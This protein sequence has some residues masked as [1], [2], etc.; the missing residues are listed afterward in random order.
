MKTKFIIQFILIFS[1]AIGHAQTNQI[2]NSGLVGIGTTNPSSYLHIQRGAITQ[3]TPLL[4]V[5][6]QQ[7]NG[8]TQ[9]ALKGTGRQF[10]LGVGNSSESSFGIANKF[11]LWDQNAVLPRFVLDANGN[12]GIGTTNPGNRLSIYSA[13]ANTSGLQFSRLNN[14]ATAA[15]GNGKVLSLDANGNVILVVDGGTTGWGMT[16]N[17]NTN[18]LTNY[19]GTSDNQPIVFKTN[20]NESMRISASGSVSIGTDDAKGYTLAVNGDAVFTRIKV[21]LYGS[22][23]DYVF[24]S[25]YQLPTLPFLEKYVSE[26]KHLPGIAS[27]S[28]VEKGGVDLAETQIALLK[29]IEEL[30]LHVI[31][32]NKRLEG[33][34]EEINVLKQS[35]SELINAK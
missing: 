11:Y 4:M 7:S 8:Y 26:N 13:T 14:T 35:L 16:G 9:I 28:E 1:T 24:D 30:T 29:K 34:V 10:H 21:K 18:A 27:A 19:I 12:I 15:T 6:D 5:E 32:L 17:A 31:Q 25:A 23:P 2:G 22:W 33:Q 20:G 3:Y